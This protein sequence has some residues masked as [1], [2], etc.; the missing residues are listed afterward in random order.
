MRSLAWLPSTT[1]EVYKSSD[2]YFKSIDNYYLLSDKVSYSHYQRRFPY[3]FD[4][5]KGYDI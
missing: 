4:D 2:L 3:N 5:Q 1:D